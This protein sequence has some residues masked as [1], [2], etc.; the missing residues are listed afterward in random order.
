M[1]RITAGH[2]RRLAAAFDPAAGH[3]VVVPTHLGK[4]GN[5]V[6]WSSVL[7]PSMRE[8]EGDV[9]AK[10]LIGEQAGELVEVELGDEAPLL[11]VDTP[12]AL[13]RLA[14]DDRA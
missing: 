10:H 3:A 8:L 12:E 4:R 2:L 13:A 14:G 9:G 11:D 7:F 5:P 1:P 6:L